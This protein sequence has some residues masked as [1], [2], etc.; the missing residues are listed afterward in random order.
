MSRRSRPKNEDKPVNR[1]FML[2]ERETALL[3]LIERYPNQVIRGLALR[4]EAEWH[5]G[6]LFLVGAIT[7]RQYEAAAYLDKTTRA[8][9]MMVRKYGHVQSAK[10]EPG[11]G[12]TRED[13]SDSVIK[14]SKRIK[15]KYDLVYGALKQC[16]A[17]VE[18]AVIDTLEKDSDADLELLRDGLTVIAAF[19]K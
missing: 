13:L 4:S 10:Y 11:S 5:Y 15:K 8:W 18:K 19:M 3:D 6:R 14:K 9:R 12:A 2:Q 17:D 1:E 7:K 16:G